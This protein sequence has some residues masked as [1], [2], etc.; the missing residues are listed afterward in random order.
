[1]FEN[2][3]FNYHRAIV[4]SKILLKQYVNFPKIKKIVVFFIINTKQYKKN[5][6]LF[7]IIIN[8]C[9]YGNIFLYNQEINNYQILKFSLR[10]KKILRFFNS[11]TYF[12]LP[13]LDG[14]QNFI[15]KS[16]VSLGKNYCFF[17][18]RFNYSNFP[19]I[20]ESE[21][22]CYSN[23]FIYSLINLYQMRFDI[24]FKSFYFVKN[25]LGFLLRMNR[26]PTLIRFV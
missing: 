26:L 19:V 16:V 25:S 5:I 18:Y 8:L 3:Y 2:S 20:P 21:F 6:L 23:E 7:Y 4:S 10:K 9:F 15:K 13:V 14:D 11:F 12:Y 24:Y 17:S 22:L 1:M